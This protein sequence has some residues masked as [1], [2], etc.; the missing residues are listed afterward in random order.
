M[1]P[2]NDTW[3]AAALTLLACASTPD[4]ETETKPTLGATAITPTGAAPQRRFSF[5]TVDDKPISHRTFQG[6]MTVIALA[7]TYDTASL[8]QIRFLQKLYK[9][10]TP[11]IN[12]L[13]LLLDPPENT[14]LLRTFASALEL[15]FPV[16]LPDQATRAG[17]GA[18]PGLHHVP[19]VVI[20]DRKG[21]EVWR[22]LG[23]SDATEL[24]SALDA[25]D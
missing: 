16:A 9:V 3:M 12:A 2:R 18:F 25:A 23:L 15:G 6:R 7:T 11:R 20:L 19:S 14:P 24:A 21:R 10:H 8:A 4:A 5:V 1:Q 22:K 13:L 17:E